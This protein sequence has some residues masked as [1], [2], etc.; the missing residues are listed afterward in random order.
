MMKWMTRLAYLYLLGPLVLFLCGW[1]RISILIPVLLYFAWLVFRLWNDTSEFKI[2]RGLA[3]AVIL[4]GGWVFLSGVGGYAFQNWDHHWRNAV[5][6]DLITHPWPVIYSAPENG[7]I[8]ELVYYVG[9]WL[10]AALV[11]KVLGWGVAN[12]ALFLW[13]WLGVVLIV[14]HMA[15]RLQISYVK[16][17][18]ILI[19]F[20]G[21][22]ALGVLLLAPEYPVLWPPV[23]HLEIWAGGPQYSS[24]T[25]QLFWVF[26][27]SVPAWLCIVL[28]MQKP[29]R[30]L[31]L[32][33]WVRC[34][35]F[36]PFVAL[37][38]LPFFLADLFKATRTAYPTPF[39]DLRFDVLLEPALELTICY[40]FYSSNQAARD[41][42]LQTLSVGQIAIFFL[43]EGGLIWLC[44]APRLWRD[45]HWRLCGILLLLIPF[46]YVGSGGDFAMRVSIAPL[47][48]LMV[49]S[50]ETIFITPSP[51]WSR[52]AIIT[53][54]GFGS[55]TP[56]YEINR[57]MYRTWEYYF[58]LPADQRALPPAAPATHL[59]QGGAP[60]NAHPYALLADDI[61]TLEFMSDKLSRNFIANVRQSLYYRF[62]APH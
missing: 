5:F 45:L 16:I 19:L 25:T 26:N 10:P 55:L 35:F 22:D 54:L 15:A 31:A 7:P 39:K 49:W 1:L 36:A 4:L 6:R 18:L 57:S 12:L 38:L 33:I 28:L 14:F 60:E 21:M 58:V 62:I 40:L 9:F 48:Y 29:R 44:L 23:S 13:T 47:F 34:F 2:Q 61:Q 17:A 53:L 37:G 43:L 30:D 52:I 3:A 50:A 41:F 20:S 51:A 32:M 59:E 56:L 42:G 46:V 8:R 24:F 27:Q 11:G